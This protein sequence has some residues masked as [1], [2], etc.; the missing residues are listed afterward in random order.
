LSLESLKAY[1]DI[2]K[3]I[4]PPALQQTIE[5]SGLLFVEL[6]DK[7][8]KKKDKKKEPKEVVEDEDFDE[9][10]ITGIPKAIQDKI[11]PGHTCHLGLREQLFDHEWDILQKFKGKNSD[12][13]SNYTDEFVMACLFA[14][15]LD[16]D[17]ALALLQNNLKFRKEKNLMKIPKM[18][19]LDQKSLLPYLSVAGTRSKLGNSITYVDPSQI[20]PGQE[21]FTVATLTR[22]MAW[23][24]FVAVFTEGMDG[25]RHGIYL[26]ADFSDLGWK[27]FDVEYNR[28]NSALWSDIF[29]GRPKK[30]FVVNPPL[31]FS[32]IFKILQTF[33][34]AKLA[35]R[36][37]TVEPKDLTTFIDKEHLIAKY[38]GSINSTREQYVENLKAWCEKHEDRFIAPGRNS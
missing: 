9:K 37:Q 24:N 16:A 23:Y 8:L 22:W 33:I 6:V 13:C 5:E 4:K 20:M 3:K 1:N 29:P 26:V 25:F 27:N 28:A 34:K 36:F 32:A 21:P 12:L 15:K 18:S 7:T 14:R 35:A 10:A 31:I 38:G 2:G 11:V 17:R 30:F 19:E